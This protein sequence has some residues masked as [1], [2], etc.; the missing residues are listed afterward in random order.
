MKNPQRMFRS[1]IE[2]LSYS[3]DTFE[4]LENNKVFKNISKV[5][6]EYLMYEHDG[7]TIRVSNVTNAL[8]S[9]REF[10]RVFSILLLVFA[11][12]TYF[13][14]LVFVKYS[15][16]NINKLVQFVD[17][18]DINSLETPVPV[19]GSPNDE[20]YKIGNALQNMISTIKEQVASLRDF[21]T[22]AS[23]ELKTPLMSLSANVDLAEKTGAYKESF[24]SIK[25]S[26]YAMNSLFETLLSIT[27]REYHHIKKTHIDCIPVIQ[28]ISTEL[29]EL[30]KEKEISFSLKLPEKFVAHCNKD[31]LHII[32]FN[33]LQNAYKYTPTWGKISVSL[34]ENTLRIHDTGIGIAQDDLSHIWDKFWKDHNKQENKEGFGLGLYLVA[35]LVRKL[36]REIAVE[37]KIHKGSTFILR[38]Q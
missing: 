30:Y 2:I 1:N 13:L 7:D 23:H 19:T 26:V 29:Q 37:S 3:E 20:I 11:V 31:M 16:K 15:L 21:V 28:D 22:H 10:V 25:R 27:K 17:T 14:S 33:M 9:Q 4:T 6:D 12:L 32:I 18:L 36:G 35:L 5:G 38:I 24:W 8:S 34:G